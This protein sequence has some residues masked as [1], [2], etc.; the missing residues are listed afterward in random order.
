MP[1]P[2]EAIP[3]SHE[4]HVNQVPDAVMDAPGDNEA[5][6]LVQEGLEFF[7]PDPEARDHA[8][9]ASREDLRKHQ[10]RAD[11]DRL[12]PGITIDVRTDDVTIP[13]QRGPLDT[14]DGLDAVT[15]DSARESAEVHGHI[16]DNG[17]DREISD[18][19]T[20]QYG[21]MAVTLS[22]RLTRAVIEEDS[23]SEATVRAQL[24]SELAAHRQD[25]AEWEAGLK[26]P[27]SD[28]Y[29][30]ASGIIQN[31]NVSDRPNLPATLAQVPSEAERQ[32]GSTARGNLRPDASAAQPDAAAAQRLFTWLQTISDDRL[33]NYFQWSESRTDKVSDALAAERGVIEQNVRTDFERL[34]SDELAPENAR[35]GL[36]RG[37]AH[38]TR[39]GALSTIESGFYQA[40]AFYAAD[41]GRLGVQRE[42]GADEVERYIH[43]NHWVFFHEEL[44][45]YDAANNTGLTYLLDKDETPLT[46]VDE[47]VK[48]HLTEASTN[49]QP[50]VLNPSDRYTEGVYKDIRELLHLV[51]TGGDDAVGIHDIMAANFEPHGTED[52]SQ[53]RVA[54]ASK[55]RESYQDMF[56]DMPPGENILHVIAKEINGASKPQQAQVIRNWIETMTEWRDEKLEL[57]MAL[58][59]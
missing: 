42:Y 19:L 32:Q 27:D 31:F 9:L 45:A 1:H 51:L 23:E 26:E 29:F 4:H 15:R 30:E 7:T 13:K 39:F 6:A 25:F 46:W 14:G 24:Q 22:E 55:L 56:P 37:F 16:T 47:A 10:D 58:S 21:H 2:I 52:S 33:I 5:T 44:H 40:A 35:D 18:D 20:Y 43:T 8:A 36:E 12:D 3:E 49:G 57:G 50:N 54:L 48:Q 53:K 41:A 34:I 28:A 17:A 38:T 11:A 59:Y